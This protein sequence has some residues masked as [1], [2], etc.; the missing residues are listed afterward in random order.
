M[1]SAI[2]RLSSY[3]VVKQRERRRGQKFTAADYRRV[4]DML[5]NGTL[6]RENNTHVQVFQKTGGQTWKAVVKKTEEGDEVYLQSLHRATAQQM[7]K[8]KKTLTEVK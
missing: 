7:T 6:F 5:D 1:P 3:T 8:A 2:V 4:Q